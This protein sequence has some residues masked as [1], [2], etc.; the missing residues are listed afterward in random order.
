[1]HT[2]GIE[3]VHASMCAMNTVIFNYTFNS[4]FCSVVVFL[5]LIVQIN[6][7]RSYVQCYDNNNV[8]LLYILNT[9]IFNELC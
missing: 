7:S 5:D 2:Y 1:M 8:L 9:V 4:R 3:Q 6:T